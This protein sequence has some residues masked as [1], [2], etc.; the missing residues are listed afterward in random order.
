MGRSTAEDW[1][2]DYPARNG[3]I[4]PNGILHG[5]NFQDGAAT[6]P[7]GFP[8]GN[9]IFAN[10]NFTSPARNSDQAITICAESASTTAAVRAEN[11]LPLAP[12]QRH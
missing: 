4:T 9:T 8:I 7:V 3:E 2:C 5:T 1:R 12:L 6:Q 11:L 10:P